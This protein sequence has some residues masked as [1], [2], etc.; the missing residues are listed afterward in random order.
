MD[1]NTRAAIPYRDPNGN[2]N[3]KEI[4]IKRLKEQQN[5]HITSTSSWKRRWEGSKI[6]KK[7]LD[8]K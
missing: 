2:A 4:L 8:L 3:S 7:L 1:L 6:N 5:S